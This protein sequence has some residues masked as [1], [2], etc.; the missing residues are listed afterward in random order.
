MKSLIVVRLWAP[1]IQRLDARNWNRAISGW[2][3]T[4]SSVANRTSVSTPLRTRSV[5]LVVLMAS[6]CGAARGVRA[7][8]GRSSAGGRNAPVNPR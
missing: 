3:F 4:A 2:A 8:C 6:P 1:A 5:V 7:A